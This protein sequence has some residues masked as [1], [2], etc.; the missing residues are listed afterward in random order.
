[1]NDLLV[2]FVCLTLSIA[3]PC[4]FF[5]FPEFWNFVASVYVKIRKKVSDEEV[6]T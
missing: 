2:F 4:L 6:K 5:L 1:M 3:L